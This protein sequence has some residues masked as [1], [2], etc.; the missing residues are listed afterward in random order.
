PPQHLA[1]FDR[2]SLMHIEGDYAF[3]HAGIR[4]RV[5]LDRQET[6][7]LLWI[8][9]EFLQSTVD[10][11]KIIVHGHSIFEAPIVRPNRIGIDTGAFASGRLTCLILEAAER[12]FLAT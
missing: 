1:F 2:L 5:S 11:G 12:A 6:Q 4:P 3:V 10:F 7:D 9:D 8:R